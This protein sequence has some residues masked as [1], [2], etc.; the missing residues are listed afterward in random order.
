AKESVQHVFSECPFTRQILQE[1]NVLFLSSNREGGWK[2]WLAK[3]FI[4]RNQDTCKFWV[5]TF[6]ALWHSHNNIYH[7]GVHQNV[8]GV[9]V[10]I[11]AYME[12]LDNLDMI[13]VE[14]DA[15]MI[16]KKINS[17][18]EDKSTIN[19]LINE[20]KEQVKR[21]VSFEFRHVHRQVNETTHL[22]VEEGRRLALPRFWVEEASRE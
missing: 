10:F 18:E 11:R 20:I 2:I 6:W 13:M 5:I 8:Y 7:E 14:G 21:F 1:L 19:V 4:H 16:I 9:L 22:L 15:L 12:E 3:E 17:L